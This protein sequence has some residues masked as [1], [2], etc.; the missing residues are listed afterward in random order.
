MN[1]FIDHFFFASMS[2][3]VVLLSIPFLQTNKVKKLCWGLKHCLPHV[4][5]QG[6]QLWKS[7]SVC[8]MALVY[9]W[10]GFF[11][12]CPQVSTFFATIGIFVDRRC[13]RVTF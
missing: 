1:L 12:P 2:T 10:V 13:G 5:E 4:R 3:N 7:N 8:R 11:I 6:F 9:V